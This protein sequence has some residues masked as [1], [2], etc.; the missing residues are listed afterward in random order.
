MQIYDKAKADFD[1]PDIWDTHYDLALCALLAEL[2][3]KNLPV[4]KKRQIGSSIGV[5]TS[6]YN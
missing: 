3:Y 4:L 5:L 1:F 2:G 6:Y